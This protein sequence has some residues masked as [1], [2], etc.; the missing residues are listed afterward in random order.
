MRAGLCALAE[1]WL[2]A[3]IVVMARLLTLVSVF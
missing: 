3:V 1:E 2:A